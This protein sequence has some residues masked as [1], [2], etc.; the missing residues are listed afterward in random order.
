MKHSKQ[1]FE[2]NGH[3]FSI[4][5]EDKA[6][7]LLV[8]CVD[9]HDLTEMS[10]EI[11]YM[12]ELSALPFTLAT[13][14]IRKWNEEISP[15]PAPP[16]FGKIPFGDGAAATLRFITE[17]LIPQVSKDKSFKAII[18]GGY[19]LSGLF[20]LWSAYQSD[21]F[22]AVVAA[23]PSVWFIGWLDYSRTNKCLAPNVYLSLGD[24]ED[25]SKNKLMATVKDAINEQKAILDEKEINNTLVWNV[26]NHFQNNGERTAKGFVWAI[27]QIPSGN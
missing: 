20:A 23:S 5:Q 12:E 11:E 6:E 8:Q 4:Y 17:E 9:S 24:R 21:V 1:D 25:H 10:T 18:L 16:V 7:V 2:S 14:N 15:W 19:S 27:K 3:S 13:V 26:G 22:D